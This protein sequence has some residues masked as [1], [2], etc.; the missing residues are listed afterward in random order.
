[1]NDAQKAGAA[2]LYP[3]P[4]ESRLKMAHPAPAIRQDLQMKKIQTGWK[5]PLAPYSNP[6]L[7]PYPMRSERCLLL[8]SLNTWDHAGARGQGGPVWAPP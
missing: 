6:R 1:M 8:L 3:A 2:G 5:G 7:A 4:Q